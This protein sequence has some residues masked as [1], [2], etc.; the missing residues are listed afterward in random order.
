[1]KDIFENAIEALEKDNKK[2]E[3]LSSLV[4]NLRLLVFLLIIY[5]IFNGYQGGSVFYNSIAII[6]TIAFVVLVIVHNKVK[7]KISKIE[8]L[9]EVNKKYI[10]RLDG[11]WIEFEDAGLEFLDNEHL[12]ANDLDIFGNYSLF[13]LLN[14]SN[15]ETGRK[16]FSKA[17]LYPS[18]EIEAIQKRQE[19]IEELSGKID[20]V[21][22]LEAI[23][24]I[25]KNKLQSPDKLIEYAKSDERVFKN[26]I[27]EL[28][29]FLPVL[30]IGFNLTLTWTDSFKYPAII[31]TVL[32]VILWVVG[33]LKNQEAL[34]IVNYLKYNLETYREMLLEI[35]KTDFESSYITNIKELM[36]KDKLS[37]LKAIKDLGRITDLV[38][39]RAQGIMNILL[40]VFFLWDYQCLFML[41]K[42]KK[43]Y[44]QEVEGWINGIGEVESLMSFSQIPNITKGSNL[45]TITGGG[46]SIKAKAMGHILINDEDRVANDLSMQNE[47]LIITGSNM[48]GKTTFLRT[49]GVNLVL[50]Y[51]GARVIAEEFSASIMEICSSMRIVD[52]LGKG[53][54]T[55]YAEILKIKKI[56]D[57]AEEGP[58]MIFLIDE[59]FRGTNSVDRIA[60]AKNVINN[61]KNSGAIGAISTHD[62]EL[63]QLD[64]GK[65]ILNYHFDDQYDGDKITFD[66]KIKK[67]ASTS[68]NA[69][70][71]MKLAG[72]KMIEG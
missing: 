60:G 20:F 51:N 2:K 31:F 28:V 55:F 23:S 61:L 63:S 16:L 43:K 48:S 36:F 17:L 1:M 29:R 8:A 67:G 9:L 25:N 66:Y 68:T 35:E 49:I 52:D 56:I 41:E 21:R 7:G 38:N 24:S 54:S 33:I 53:I 47:I 10:K 72:I 5:A 58:N 64:D 65:R 18:K 40:N 46:N 70:N 45:P 37:S 44:G 13:K 6:S 62:L 14:L 12:Y 59:I 30:M 22:E 27:M 50:C 42:W 3:K 39:I 15:T 69:R 4:A 19:A 11:T 34:S 57:K 71:L 32:Q 26:S